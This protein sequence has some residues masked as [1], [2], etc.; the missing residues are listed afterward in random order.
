MLIHVAPWHRSYLT[1]PIMEL[2]VVPYNPY[3]H[4]A[5]DGCKYGF[6]IFYTASWTKKHSVLTG[7]VVSH[8]Y[9]IA[10][11]LGKGGKT[12]RQGG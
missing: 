9:L 7:D 1:R 3:L 4:Y 11:F 10:R 2:F 12:G 8:F 6:Y 5:K